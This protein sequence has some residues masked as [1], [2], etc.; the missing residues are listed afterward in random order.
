MPISTSKLCISRISGVDNS[1]I[2][3]ASNSSRRE[4]SAADAPVPPVHDLHLSQYA[5]AVYDGDW[6]LHSPNK[7]FMTG[8]IKN[9]LV[10]CRTQGF[11]NQTGGCIWFIPVDAYM[12]GSI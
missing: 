2:V 12:N 7:G 1:T 3:V 10:L 9:P 4:E 6:Y 11:Q 8:S 5:A